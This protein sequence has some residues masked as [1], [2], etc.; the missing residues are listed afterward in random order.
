MREVIVKFKAYKEMVKYFAQYSSYKLPKEKWVESMGFL[1]CNVEGDYYIVEDAIGMTSGSELDV[2]LS[3]QSLGN[4]P[5]LERE[6]GGF[7]GGWWHTHP[8][9]SPFFSETDIKNQVFYQTANPDG[10]G[11]VFDHS[12]IEKDFI[13]FQI[14]RLIHQ[15][16]EEYVDVPFQLQGFTNEG[17][18]ECMDLLGVDKDTIDDLIEKFGG[19]G[20]GLKIDFSKLG[21]PLVDDPLDDSD[22]ILMEADDL[23][24]KDKIIEAIKKYKMT[25]II[26]EN[27][28]H[29]EKYREVLAKL[30][31]LCAENNFPENAADELESFKKLEGKIENQAFENDLERLTKLISLKN[32]E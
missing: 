22:W 19:K 8:G 20:A 17:I 30:I 23:L 1:F 7:V 5:D 6:R 26:L 13:G 11:I 2:Q 25:T 28:E 3:P 9:L 16:S 24:K 15:F 18:K 31:E 14:F 10:L 27:T 4:I 29:L 32:Q 21:E 12:M